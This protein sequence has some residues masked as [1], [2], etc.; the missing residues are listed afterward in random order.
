M[1]A[2]QWAGMPGRPGTEA[3]ALA[4]GAH[5]RRLGPARNDVAESTGA[6]QSSQGFSEERGVQE[7]CVWLHQARQSQSYL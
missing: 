7:A 1:Q 3:A 4:T 2:R 6:P 5:V